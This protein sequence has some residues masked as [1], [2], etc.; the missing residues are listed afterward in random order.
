MRRAPRDP[1]EPLFGKR[2][3]IISLVQGLS[4]LVVVLLVFLIAR[5]LGRVED[6]VRA[7]TVVTL[8][9]SNLALILTNRSWTRTIWETFKSRNSALMWVLGGTITF[10]FLILY[11]PFLR[12]LFR[13]S[14]LHPLDL[15]ICVLAAAVSIIWFEAL[16]F[17]RQRRNGNAA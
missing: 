8:I 14:I 2:I 12:N 16:K 4:V 7:L 15:L 5:G 9:L 13:F 11:V 6:E 3:M 17:I 10:V 1:K